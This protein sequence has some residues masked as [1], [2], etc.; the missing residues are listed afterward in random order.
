[1]KE[2]PYRF[3]I[4]HLSAE[5]R[6]SD[7]R[8]KVTLECCYETPDQR[9]E[10]NRF[11][12]G[13]KKPLRAL[14]L[15]FLVA[16]TPQHDPMGN[17]Y[18]WFRDYVRDPKIYSDTEA[19]VFLHEVNNVLGYHPISMLQI[20]RQYEVRQVVDDKESWVSEGWLLAKNG[21]I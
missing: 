11:L 15:N 8:T 17:Q 4:H 9:E 21:R 20:E 3:Y 10:I 2:P 18:L 12:A 16:G 6:G 1:M 13:L 19:N 5:V 7:G 14:G